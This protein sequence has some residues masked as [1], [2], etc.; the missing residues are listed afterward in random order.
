LL[1]RKN[2][3]AAMKNSTNKRM[4][5][6]NPFTIFQPMLTDDLRTIIKAKRG[7]AYIP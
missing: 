4:A 7:V 5:I 6:I 2:T 3:I 1:L